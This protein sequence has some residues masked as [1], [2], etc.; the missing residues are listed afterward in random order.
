MDCVVRFGDFVTRNAG[1]FTAVEMNPVMV[2]PQG[3]GVAVAD[4]LITVA[5]EKG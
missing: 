2:R 1:R 5:A 4:A 3:L